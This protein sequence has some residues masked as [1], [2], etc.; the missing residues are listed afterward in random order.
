MRKL[1]NNILSTP[2]VFEI[3]DFIRSN[4]YFNIFVSIL[5]KTIERTELTISL[6]ARIHLFQG[7]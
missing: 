4:L 6:V 5:F 1:C 2:R 7:E 3:E